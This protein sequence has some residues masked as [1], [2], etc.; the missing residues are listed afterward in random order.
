MREVAG[1]RRSG[2][3]ALDLAFVAAGRY[4]GYWERNLQPWDLAAGIVLIR[5]AGGFVSD[6]D[7]GEKMLETG[8][9]L[10]ANSTLQKVLLPMIGNGGTKS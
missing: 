10:A 6:L 1:I 8:D 9:V 5:E 4:D 7:G 2:S 3:A